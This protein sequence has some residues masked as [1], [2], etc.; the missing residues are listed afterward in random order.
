MS[1][2][3]TE[4][5]VEATEVQQNVKAVEFTSEVNIPLEVRE[6]ILNKA[7]EL[8]QQYKLRK[9]FI[10]LVE[11]EDDD[12][13]FYVAYLRRPSLVHFSQYMNFAQ[14]DVVQAN[15]MLARNVFLA[16]DKEL[17]DDEDLFLYGLMGQLNHIID[18]RNA[19][20][21]KK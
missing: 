9:I 14:K 11:G 10:A 4:Q 1:R 21:V 18:S 13:P 12:K 7:E 17:V 3:K 19:D 8:K 5:E 20:L 16:G 6:E 15:Q 2:T